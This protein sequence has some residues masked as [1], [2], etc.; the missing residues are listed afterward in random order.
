MVLFLW[1]LL[2]R[3]KGRSLP[4]LNHYYNFSFRL[5]SRACSGKATYL[6]TV[7]FVCFS[8]DWYF[9][10]EI[11]PRWPCLGLEN[12]FQSFLK[13][14]FRGHQSFFV[15]PLIPPFWTFGDV[16]PGFQSKGRPLACFLTCVILRLICG[17][18]PADC[19]NVM[20]T[21]PFWSTYLHILHNHW[22][23]FRVRTH[24]HTCS[25][26]NTLAQLYF[27]SLDASWR[28]VLKYTPAF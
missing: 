5:V 21:K 22:W 2:C 24:D 6:L 12:T 10:Q 7:V 8:T 23:R 14:D 17:A 13:K 28:E 26:H 20:A 19:I 3:A 11:N 27:F 1:L 16:C 15:L 18:T 4:S 9:M 25:Q